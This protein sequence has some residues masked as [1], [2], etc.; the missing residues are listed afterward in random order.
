[1]AEDKNVT[2]CGETRPLPVYTTDAENFE[3]TLNKL[4]RNSKTKFMLE[5]THGI[6]EAT[7]LPCQCQLF[8]T[9]LVTIQHPAV[10]AP[11]PFCDPSKSFL[12]LSLNLG[13]VKICAMNVN[14]V[15][16]DQANQDCRNNF[17]P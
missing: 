5:I 12:L 9:L 13:S 14:P 7:L 8:I 3:S 15:A 1:M 4:L 10:L 11:C 6:A 16:G 17:W 2:A